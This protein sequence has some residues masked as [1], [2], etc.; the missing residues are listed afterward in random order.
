MALSKLQ[1]FLARGTVVSWRGQPT[2]YDIEALRANS[3]RVRLV[4]QARWVIVAT[5]AVY[6]IVAAAIYASAP[7]IDQVRDS[8]LTAAI[9]LV[10]VLLYNGVY[11]LTYKRLANIAYL[12][13][14]QLV[15]DCVVATVLVYQSG[16][17]QSWFTAM[18]LFFILEGTF[19]LAERKQV[20]RLVVISALLYGSVLAGEYLGVLPHQELPFV[21]N[22]LHH[23]VTYVVVRYL[24]QVTLFVGVAFLGML[25]MKSMRERER[26]LRE[27][28][29]FD[30]LTGLFNRAYF[31]RVLSSEI[32]RAVRDGRCVGL[33]LVD[34]D[35]FAEINRTFG[36]E[37]A[38]ELLAA[39]GGE[40][41]AAA[42][43]D[44]GDD[45][46]DVSVACRIGGEELALV[47]P[48]VARSADDQ[49]SLSERAAGIAEE[50]RRRVES[51]RMSG[52]GVTVS[53]GVA[54]GPQDGESFDALFDAA[55]DALGIAA[56][57]G[58]NAVRTTWVDGEPSDACI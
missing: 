34:V 29:F 28:S 22:Y 45:D 47:V 18:Y 25:M 33:I 12:N 31:Q 21:Y 55:S 19:I 39:I 3:E 30:D 27:S 2:Q 15:F 58:G 26:E 23:T 14:M 32:Q 51:T 1:R 5:L 37:V 4:I 17:V 10:F 43:S 56:A 49:A 57:G 6:S 13:Q 38:D 36:V 41:R 53:I 9:A 46:R 20:W 50:I 8:M 42:R 54:I 48:E 44:A 11:Q 16:G 7:E 24:W 40:L 35:E 52:V